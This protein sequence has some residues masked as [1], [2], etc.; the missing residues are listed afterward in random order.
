MVPQG[1]SGQQP[2]RLPLADVDD[3]GFFKPQVNLNSHTYQAGYQQLD[4]PQNQGPEFADPDDYHQDRPSFTVCSSYSYQGCLICIVFSFRLWIIIVAKSTT[5]LASH[6]KHP[7]SPLK[8]WPRGK[9]LATTSRQSRINSR[10][11]RKR[12]PL[13]DRSLTSS[14]PALSGPA[15]RLIL[16]VPGVPQSNQVLDQDLD[17]EQVIKVESILDQMQDRCHLTKES[18][19]KSKEYH[20]HPTL[21]ISLFPICLKRSPIALLEHSP[22]LWNLAASWIQSSS[23]WTLLERLDSRSH[24]LHRSTKT[25]LPWKRSFTLQRMTSWKRIWRIWSRKSPGWRIQS[26]SFSNMNRKWWSRHLK[27]GLWL[28]HNRWRSRWTSGKDPA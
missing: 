17:L 9:T 3:E 11:R 2:G 16:K 8:S 23:M 13:A 22:I 20:N 14:F 6:P 18:F 19:H 7:R 4:F 24:L 5:P 12:S 28:V 21:L 1:A 27:E 10:R 25:T 15:I 26:R